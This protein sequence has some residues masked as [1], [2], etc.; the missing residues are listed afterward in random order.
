MFRQDVYWVTMPLRMRA[1]RTPSAFPDV[2]IDKAIARLCGGARSPTRGSIIWGVTVVIA[3][4]KEMAENAAKLL[5]VQRPILYGV[6]F[7]V[8]WTGPDEAALTTTWP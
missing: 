2:T 5:V 8:C 1:R 7:N 4:K 3:V 6:Y